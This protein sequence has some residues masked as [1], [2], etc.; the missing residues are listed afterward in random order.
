MPAIGTRT[1][2][3]TEREVRTISSSA[4]GCFSILVKC[5]VKIAQPEI[6]GWALWILALD[7]QVLLADGGDVI[8]GMDQE[9]FSPHSVQKLA[10]GCNLAPHFLHLSSW[11]T[12]AP[13]SG[14]NFKCFGLGGHCIAACGA[15]GLPPIRF[16]EVLVLFGHGSM[17]PNLFG[18]PA[19]LAADISTPK[20][21]AH[22]LHS[23]RFSFQQLFRQTH[24]SSVDTGQTQ[25]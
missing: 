2:L 10:P 12:L 4:R 14:Q 6:T 21:G 17:R 13:H 20:S 19:G 23:P 9:V 24:E 3:A 16:C 25:I 22:S 1:P 15:Y 11:I 18:G 7:L 5:L 8:T